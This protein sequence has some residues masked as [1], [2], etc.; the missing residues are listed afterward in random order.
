MTRFSDWQERLDSF[1]T[2]NAKNHFTYGR[3]DCCLFVCDAIRTMTGIDPAEG[4]RESYVTRMGAMVIA[5]RKYGRASVRTIAERVT[6]KRDMPAC[7]PTLAHRGDLV[8]FKRPND[9]SLGIVDL[10]GRFAAILTQS[11]IQRLPVEQ[12]VSAWH[13]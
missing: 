8:M 7:L 12:A 3:W 11:G 13:V 6:A 1:L 4:F 2:S 5:K 9:Y 10:S